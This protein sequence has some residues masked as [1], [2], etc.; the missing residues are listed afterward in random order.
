MSRPD[1]DDTT[2]EDVA[3]VAGAQNTREKKCVSVRG[4]PWMGVSLPTCGRRE[5][6]EIVI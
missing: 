2:R 1:T 6:L 3:A 4:F 5:L